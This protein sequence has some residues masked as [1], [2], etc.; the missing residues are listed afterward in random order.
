MTASCWNTFIPFFEP[1]DPGSTDGVP[2]NK[3]DAILD[4]VAD[5]S[6]KQV[7]IIACFMLFFLSGKKPTGR[8]ASALVIDFINQLEQLNILRTG[9]PTSLGGRKLRSIELVRSVATQ[10]AGG[11][12]KIYHNVTLELQEQIK[13]QRE[14]DRKKQCAKGAFSNK[15]EKDS[16]AVGQAGSSDPRLQQPGNPEQQQETASDLDLKINYN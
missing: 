13:Q 16:E 5:K 11:L 6:D 7:N 9:G 12:R 1:K 15:Q 8:G 3:T 10:L 14:K 2:Q 4:E